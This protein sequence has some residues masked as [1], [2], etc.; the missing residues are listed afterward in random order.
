MQPEVL[1]IPLFGKGQ[2]YKALLNMLP[3]ALI[4]TMPLT[5]LET[6]LHALLNVLLY[7]PSN[8]LISTILN[9]RHRL[10]ALLYM[11]LYMLHNV[12]INT[13]PLDMLP[14]VL[15]STSGSISS[16]IYSSM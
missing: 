13:M 14:Y 6:E 1:N 16:S 15:I 2:S 3:D 8:V 9:H 4:N 5:D 10:Y 7:M 12:L 11:L